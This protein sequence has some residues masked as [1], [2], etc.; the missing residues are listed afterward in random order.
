MQAFVNPKLFY[1]NPFESPEK[2]R[3]KEEK[4]KFNNRNLTAEI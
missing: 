1:I 2:I 3:P 4:I